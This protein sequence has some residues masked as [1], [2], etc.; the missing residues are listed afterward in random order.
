MVLHLIYSLGMEI[1]FF[2]NMPSQLTQL[3][4]IERNNLPNLEH[5]SMIIFKKLDLFYPSKFSHNDVI[6]MLFIF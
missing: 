1:F 4:L 2:I 3:S 6:G 5:I